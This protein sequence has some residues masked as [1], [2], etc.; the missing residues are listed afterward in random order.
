VGSGGAYGGSR[1]GKWDII[2][3]FSAYVSPGKCGGLVQG[4]QLV[5][6]L[7][8]VE[9][10]HKV[11]SLCFSWT[12]WRIITSLSAYVSPGKCGALLQG[13]QLV[14][15]LDSVE[16]YHKVLACVSPGKCGG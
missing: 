1:I 4:F 3:R 11:F 14:F 15:L 13:F 10:Y 6:L 12:V 5:F 16:D 9:D 2:P 7:D 8:S